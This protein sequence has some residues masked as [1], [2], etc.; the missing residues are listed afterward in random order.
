MTLDSI[1]GQAV[2]V[3]ILKNGLASGTLGHAYLLAGEAGL[4]K[5]T[6]ARAAAREL[7]KL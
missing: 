7:Q 4:G 6:T 2:P 3:A 1:V 5:E